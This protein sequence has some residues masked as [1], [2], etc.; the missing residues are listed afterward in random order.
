MFANFI[1]SG[2]EQSV[3]LEL[4]STSWPEEIA[5]FQEVYKLVSYCGN[6]CTMAI[7]K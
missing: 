6:I 4:T 2:P 1:I 3:S 7:G 5:H